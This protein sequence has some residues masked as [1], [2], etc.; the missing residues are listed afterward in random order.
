MS[1]LGAAVVGQKP[2]CV[3][4]LLQ[5]CDKK[6]EDHEGLSPLQRAQGLASKDIVEMLERSVAASDSKTV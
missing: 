2:N 5:V 1:P 3:L 6:L 4:L